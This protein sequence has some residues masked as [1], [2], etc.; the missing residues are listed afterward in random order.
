MPFSEDTV[1]N[2]GERLGSRVAE[3]LVVELRQRNPPNFHVRT[4]VIKGSTGVP[5]ADA[6]AVFTG[7]V[8]MNDGIVRVTGSL[9][10][11]ASKTVLWNGSV[12]SNFGDRPESEYGLL[13]ENIAFLIAQKQGVALMERHE[14]EFALGYAPPAEARRALLEARILSRRGPAR[15]ARESNEHVRQ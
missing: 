12:E 6:D 11:Q 15:C 8:S 4:T 1:E 14:E 2:P 13:F 7:V 10:H 5:H 9:E 3:A